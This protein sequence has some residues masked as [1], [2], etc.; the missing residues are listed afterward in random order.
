[1]ATAEN[2]FQLPVLGMKGLLEQ[3]VYLK[4]NRILDVAAYGD[5]PVLPDVDHA[6]FEGPCSGQSKAAL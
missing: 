5:Q 4:A 1:M 3:V 6:L 2:Y